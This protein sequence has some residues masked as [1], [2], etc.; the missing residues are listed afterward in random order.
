MGK[1]TR[2]DEAQAIDAVE[3]E[4][5]PDAGLLEPPLKMVEHGKVTPASERFGTTVSDLLAKSTRYDG[6]SGL[7]SGT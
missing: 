1:S 4:K 3:T 7:F 5:R 2:L 6:G